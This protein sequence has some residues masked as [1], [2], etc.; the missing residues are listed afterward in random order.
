MI[1]IRP[2]FKTEEKKF[3]SSMAVWAVISR[4]LLLWGTA[5]VILMVHE[6]LL[7]K[8]KEAAAGLNW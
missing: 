1:T 6:R 8:V 5:S 3:L 7:A 2:Y 4:L